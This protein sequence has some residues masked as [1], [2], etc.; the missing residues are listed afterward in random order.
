MPY[1]FHFS[2]I[3][4]LST[5]AALPQTPPAPIG[6]VFTE[7]LSNLI[8]AEVSLETFNSQYLQR[9]S[10]NGKAVLA[11]ARV[12]RRLEAPLVEVESVLFGLFAQDV[13]LE[14]YVRL[15]SFF[16]AAS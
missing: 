11:T 8:P 5:A 6:P 16:P 13:Q 15:R 2:V 10:T 1:I 14:I 9:H 4:F 3:Q 7:A 12:L